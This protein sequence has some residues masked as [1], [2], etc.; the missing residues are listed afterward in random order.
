VKKV[1]AIIL[2]ALMMLT[3]ISCGTKDDSTS[4]GTNSPVPSTSGGSGQGS[5]PSSSVQPSTSADT[6]SGQSSQ[7]PG[8]GPTVSLKVWGSQDDQAMLNEMIDAFKA[9]NPDK[10]WD[11]SLMVV[12]ENDARTKY[13]EDPA[14]AAD[15]FA[16]AHDQLKE[17]VGAGALYEVAGKWKDSVLAENGAGSIDAASRDGK[18]YA[19]PMTAD[20]G[21]FMYYD[22]SVFSAS[23]VQ[24]FDKMLEVAAAA[25]KKVYM[26]I[27][28][29]WYIASFFLAAG[30]HVGLNADGSAFCT[31]N[32]ANGL[33]AAEGIKAIVGNSAYIY[34]DGAILTGGIGDTV[35]AGVSGTWDA[36][37]IK[38]KLGAN[39][40][41][42]KL[43]TFTCGGAQVQMSSF[44]GYKLVGVNRSTSSPQEAMDLAAWLTNYDNQLKRFE[45]RSMG[46]SNTKAAESPEVQAA[47]ELAALAA[48]AAYAV[49]QNDVPDNFW[50]PTK[51]LGQQL[52]AGDNSPLQELLDEMVD[53]IIT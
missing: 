17:L 24:S 12:G 8:S 46:P 41:A 11:I 7:Q 27:G 25:N 52:I 5:Q 20:N 3:L 14:A 35:A 47:A 26:D 40:N 21:Y 43:P 49:A 45:M 28:N 15:V 32:D 33:K 34:G 42:C 9:A 2:V 36:A 48:Q 38:E 1:I 16:F 51:A 10:T 29:G 53:K 30:C 23:D 37:A 31:F 4:S 19:F 13:L 22:S 6:G 44:A 50:E 18:L 39:Y